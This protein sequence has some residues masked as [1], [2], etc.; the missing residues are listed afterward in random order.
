MSK[1]DKFIDSS[2]RDGLDW[3]FVSTGA[4]WSSVTGDD[5]VRD[6]ISTLYNFLCG[7]PIAIKEVRA[8]VVRILESGWDT[9]RRGK[10]L[11]MLFDRNYRPDLARTWTVDFK[12][13]DG[14]Q[15][16]IRRDIMVAAGM[17]AV[18]DCGKSYNE[19]IQWAAEQWGISTRRVRVVNVRGLKK[20]LGLKD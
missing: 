12:R 14:G 6:D 13:A 4:G 17:Q 1:T 3:L 11:C 19:A 5:D 8:A 9:M 7:E 18:R 10:T 2:D 15:S 16:K 20:K